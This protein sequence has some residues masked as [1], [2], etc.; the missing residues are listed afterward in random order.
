MCKVSVITIT[1]NAETY[2]E[3]TMLSVLTQKYYDFEYIVKDGNSSDNTN[4]I[5][6]KIKQRYNKKIIKHICMRDKGIYDAMN[7]AVKHAC[8]EWIIFMN[9]GDT[10]YDEYVL[11]NVFS[12]QHE[13]E[14][15][16]LYG[17]VFMKLTGNRG[18]V[19]TYNADIMKK[20][21]SI[22]HQSVFEKRNFLIRAPFDA[23]LQ[24]LA[25][26]D[27]FLWLMN[28]NV[29]FQ[30]INIIVAKEDRNGISSV[31]YPQYYNEV[32]IVSNRYNLHYR[33]KIIQIEKIKVF[34]KKFIPQI[35]EM[36]MIRKALK[37]NS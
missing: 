29:K 21:V 13:N 1:Y 27:H 32:R 31:N 36:V 11:S 24:I 35:E 25:D 10:F 8:G 6:N 12:I 28:N 15:G 19:L 16:V 2:I 18:L 33:K 9:A 17:H 3:E 37:R 20:G 30:K 14:I 22:C 4:I 5:V 23:D 34:I 26:R 7:E